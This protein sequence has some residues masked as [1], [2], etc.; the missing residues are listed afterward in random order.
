MD[1]PITTIDL[2]EFMINGA[3][4]FDSPTWGIKLR[5]KLGLEEV[6]Q[7]SSKLIFLIPEEAT[8]ISIGF[9]AELFKDLVTHF[10]PDEFKNKIVIDDSRCSVNVQAYVNNAIDTISRKQRSGAKLLESM[11]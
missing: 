9:F 11:L 8:N 1:L 4:S 7:D 3:N 2:R 6:F 10:G 5:H